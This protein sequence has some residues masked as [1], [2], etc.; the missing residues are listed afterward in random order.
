MDKDELLYFLNKNCNHRSEW[1]LEDLYERKSYCILEC[2]HRGR[3]FSCDDECQQL[4]SSCKETFESYA[5]ANLENLETCS[6]CI[7]TFLHDFKLDRYV[8]PDYLKK[9]FLQFQK[10]STCSCIKPI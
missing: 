6:V 4:C 1:K 10:Q 9:R 5:F 3:G 2:Y 7:K 8:H